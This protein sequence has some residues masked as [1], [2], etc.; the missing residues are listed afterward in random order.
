[1]VLHVE[2]PFIPIVD[3][4]AYS[5]ILEGDFSNDVIEA[6]FHCPFDYQCEPSGNS[7]LQ[8]LVEPIETT[9]PAHGVPITPLRVWKALV[10]EHKLSRVPVSEKI[11]SQQGLSKVR[12]AFPLPG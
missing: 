6:S 7:R 4:K 9:V 2:P 1:M 5:A 3:C 8:Q 12:I 11:Q 10:C